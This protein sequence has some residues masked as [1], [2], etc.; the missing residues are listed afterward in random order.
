MKKV[1]VYAMA[2]HGFQ[3]ACQYEA[4]LEESKLGNEVL[5]LYCDGILDLC[6]E[7]TSCDRT[8]CKFCA[9]GFRNRAKKYLG[10]SVKMIPLSNYYTDDIKNQE[11]AISF[12]Y[13]NNDELKSL[14]FHGVD[15][16]YGALS[17]YIT[18]TRNLNPNFGKK[19]IREY[20]DILLGVE[21]RLSLILEKVLSEFQPDLVYFHNGRFV[22][23][24]PAFR[25]PQLQG[26]PFICT[27]TAYD[28][29]QNVYQEF[30][31]GDIPH[32]MDF[33]T[34]KMNRYWN[35]ETNIEERE[36][37][38]SLFFNNRRNAKFSG[39]KIYV[40]GQISGK[41][42]DGF[43]S[44][45]ENIV[46]FNS[47]E[48]EMG[49]IGQEVEK[50][51]LF[52]SQYEGIITIAERY[53]NDKT[54]HFY[55]R[56]HP[57]LKNVPYDY[58]V[59][60]LKL[61]Y[62]NLTVIP[63]DSDISTYALMDAAD[64]VIVFGSTTGAEASY[65]GKPVICLYFAFY[66]KLGCVYTPASVD[67]AWKLIETKNLEPA[68]GK[69][70]MKYGYFFLSSNKE[71]FHQLNMDASTFKFRGRKRLY[72]AIY[73]LF[74]STKMAYVWDLICSVVYNKLN[75]GRYPQIPV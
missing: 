56:I 49:A 46:I 31:D 11:K 57:S 22:Y 30:I 55:L 21:I 25:L 68:D 58:H 26:I 15:V 27:E 20:F 66:Y 69:A 9:H 51:S 61:D 3:E 14:D 40:K 71:K 60:L 18:W 39:D 64:K 48:D 59:N 44:K 37:I 24:K 19:E 38:G 43:D 29:N 1:L 73:K 35:A 72:P 10:S 47:S 4:A 7:N 23:F 2:R 28:I 12:H 63:G 45:I 41:L 5:F 62:P 36:R 65:W 50:Y 75:R 33:W 34:K 52:K 54:K 16:G 70:S 53:M 74:G 17:T 6:G 8:K 13:N 32:S 67:E 42:P